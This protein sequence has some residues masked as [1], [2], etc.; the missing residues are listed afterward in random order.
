MDLV[1]QK[2]SGN[3]KGSLEKKNNPFFQYIKEVFKKPIN[4]FILAIVIVISS[5]NTI[6]SLIPSFVMKMIT[7][8]MT[9]NHEISKVITI[10]IVFSFVSLII[11]YL[12][13]I[14]QGKLVINLSTNM[15]QQQFNHAYSGLIK[16]P[17]KFFYKTSTGDIQ[18]RFLDSTK[19]SGTVL[20]LLFSAFE[21][22]VMIISGTIIAMISK[23]ILLSSFI[24]FLGSILA[25]LLFNNAL[26]VSA[27]KTAIESAK[28]IDILR[29]STEGII[30][31]KAL[32]AE[33]NIKNRFNNKVNDLKC[34]ISK[35]SII[36]IKKNG[37]SEIIKGIGFLL[38]IWMS[39]T[40]ITTG[41]MALGNLVV[42]SSLYS[43]FMSPA[44]SFSN[45]YAKIVEATVE[46]ERLE[47]ITDNNDTEID[48]DYCGTI[49][50]G[51]VKVRDLCFGYTS[52][53][54][55]DNFNLDIS[56]GECVAIIGESGKGKSTLAKI[57]S[58][59]E[60]PKCG[61]IMVG[62]ADL[63]TVS[64]I[65]RTASLQYIPQ[66]PFFLSDS[67]RTNLLLGIEENNISDDEIYTLLDELGA[68]FVSN[69]DD[70][71]AENGNNLSGGQRQK[72]A[73]ARSILRKP[74]ILIMDESTSSIDAEGQNNVFNVIKK[75]PCTKIIISHDKSVVSMCDKKIYI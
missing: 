23:K 52:E 75:L 60:K 24:V 1:I 20:Q 2:E 62:G 69:L 50:D 40:D 68:D 61:N 49:E 9:V 63:T 19:I 11:S 32:N 29:E 13:K 36:N 28:T 48:S 5:I 54:I 3:I 17:L 51:S 56:N 34:A 25:S 8:S 12:F 72:L 42:L 43:Y 57:I 73:I 45:L 55:I 16:R 41:K 46:A 7:D 21:L 27:H 4:I 70:Q 66:F 59:I 67:F 22:V 6:L 64:A 15:L 33:N 44:E 26:T 30:T 53:N 31:I 35:S 38:M 10:M 18:E 37:V 58:G 71:I 65:K 47:E 74:K 14:L 39:I